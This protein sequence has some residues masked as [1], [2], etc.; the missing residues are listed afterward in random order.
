MVNG[1]G[2]FA[3][4]YLLMLFLYRALSDAEYEDYKE[5]GEF[6]TAVNTLEAKQFFLARNTVR[7][8]VASSVLQGY[9]PP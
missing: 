6:R 5:S 3:K 2:D 1:Y 7:K 4:T 9:Y 8:F